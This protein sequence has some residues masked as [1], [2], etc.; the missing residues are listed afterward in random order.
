MEL[1]I[2]EETC[3]RS[4]SLAGLRFPVVADFDFLAWS[5]WATSS[6]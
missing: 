6:A 3:L 4:M 5:P 2:I 1:F